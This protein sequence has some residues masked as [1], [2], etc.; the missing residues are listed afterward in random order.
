VS[1]GALLIYGATGYSGRLLA[2]AAL[3][4][5]LRPVL[6]GRDEAKLAALAARLGLAYRAARLDHPAALTEAL[7]DVHVVLHAAGPF[8]QT[9]RPM[10][11][12]CL[13]AGVHYLDLSAGIDE[14]EALVG[15]DAEARGR[16]VMLMPAVGF[17]VVPSDCLAAHVARRL[18]GAERLA[19]GIHGLTLAT[20]GSA[21]AFAEYAG[22]DIL[23]RRNGALRTVPPGTLERDFDF[24][25]GPRAS[26]AVSWGDV[27]AAYYTTG[28]PNVE[29]YFEA[30]PAMRS[31]LLTTR[32]FGP[33]LR[34]GISQAMLKT[35][36]DML[37]E[38]PTPAQRAAAFTVL[39]AESEDRRGRRARARLYAPEAYTLT[40]LTATAIARRTLAGDLEVGFQTPGRVY[41]PDFVLGFTGVR[42]EDLE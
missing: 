39:V 18:P 11:D 7:R 35:W 19:I 14:I 5:G 41:G 36:S 26:S 40:A 22:R 10:V 1:A 8:S 33:L 3:A 27:S 9:A 6:A 34:S 25:D 23:V 37:P 16:G 17:D 31:M 12:A 29:V 4:T 42:R 21:K 20:R 28:I 2:D 30:T 13:Q 32:A 15:R 38:G 24:G